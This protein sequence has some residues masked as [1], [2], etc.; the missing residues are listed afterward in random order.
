AGL[1]DELEKLLVLRRT[2]SQRGLGES[3]QALEGLDLGVPVARLRRDALETLLDGG[4]ERGG[5]AQERLRERPR[6]E[7]RTPR[8]GAAGRAEPG[9]LEL[10]RHGV[11]LRGGV[12]EDVARLLARSPL[13]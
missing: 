10:A 8:R 11:L 9:L 7:A 2:A 1:G 13:R 12:H 4:Q 5:R 6:E 3:P